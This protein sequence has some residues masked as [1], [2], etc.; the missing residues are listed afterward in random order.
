MVVPCYVVYICFL[1]L[2]KANI[3]F[4]GRKQEI[5]KLTEQLLQA[6]T[7]GDY[8]EYTYEFSSCAKSFWCDN[9]EASMVNLFVM[10]NFGVKDTIN[11]IL[12]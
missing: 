9:H 3:S 4:L 7:G 2:T 6:V 12:T 10:C 1:E 8:G 5:I 11:S